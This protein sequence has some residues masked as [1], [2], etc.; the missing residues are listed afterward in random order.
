MV[1]G[2]GVSETLY[3]ADLS[4]HSDKDSIL[5]KTANLIER[6][7][8]DRQF[9]K[10]NDL[11]GI[12]THF[13]EIGL[14]T[15]LRPVFARSVVEKIKEKGANPF[16]F[17]TTTLYTSGKRINAVGHL[18]TAIK[19]GF[20]YATIGAPIII[21]DGL[22]GA[23]YIEVE[24]NGKKVKIASDI[25]HMDAIVCLSHFKGHCATGFG[26]TL[27]NLSMGMA[28][29]AGKLDM[30]SQTKPYINNK[31]NGCGICILI[32]PVGA[33]EKK[34]DKA[35]IN[36]NICIGC[37]QCDTR[38][39]VGAIRFNWDTPANILMQR[40]AEY[41][42]AVI[43]IKGKNMAYLNFLLD[44]TPDC[45]C[46]G[47]SNAPICHNIGVLASF[48]PLAIDQASVDLINKETGQDIFR[49]LWP[50]IDY[51]YILRYAE[52]FGIGSREYKIV[53]I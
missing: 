46:Y 2:A 28:S 5:I 44:I 53:K 40:M 48:D 6:L 3:F 34:G 49:K 27:K 30:H 16:L 8:K 51:E 11:V 18:T 37:M 26:G 15:F 39:P 31:C 12:K 21:A 38:C 13:G 10:K 36:T 29:R 4:A 19:N 32:C 33:I 42:S 9:F 45:D 52:E 17:D 24:I 22:T 20:S 14:A 41:A 23:N 1:E 50:K 43:K 7:Y 35:F 47:Y 25:Q